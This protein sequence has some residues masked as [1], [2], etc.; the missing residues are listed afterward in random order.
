MSR[1]KKTDEK[2]PW[3]GK[4][5]E[6]DL[7]IK[8]QVKNTFLIYCEGANTEP[9]YFK[10][11][12]VNTETIVLAIGLGMSRSSL[13]KEII[14]RVSEQGYLEGQPNFDEDRQIWCAFDRDDRGLP[15]EDEDFDEAVRLAREHSLH[16][17]YSNDAF[18]LW[19]C[20]HDHYID[21]QLHR[22]QFYER[23]SKRLGLN[24]EVHGKE[25]E[26]AK[27]LYMLF[28]P[29]QAKAIL[30]AERLHKVHEVEQRPSHHNPCTT[31]YQLVAALNKCLKQ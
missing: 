28:L 4:K 27:S 2:K 6:R 14:R 23:L 11:F 9:E 15:G 3:A 21:T 26:F 20:L 24:Y 5:L 31:V 18:E 8:R 16:V 29:F 25:K 13:V 19:F 17:A 10:A 30:H 1:I 7:S 22:K 12:P